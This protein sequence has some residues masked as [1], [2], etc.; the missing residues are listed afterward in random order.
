MLSSDLPN[1]LHGDGALGNGWFVVYRGIT[2]GVYQSLCVPFLC[3][4]SFLLTLLFCSLEAV[5]N[6]GGVRSSLY[7]GIPTREEAI[8]KYQGAVA[9]GEVAAVLPVYIE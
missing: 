4:P 2:P 7:E 8:N 1:P 6:T 3:T 9:R 5:L